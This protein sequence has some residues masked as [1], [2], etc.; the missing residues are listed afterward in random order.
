MRTPILLSPKHAGSV[1]YSTNAKEDGSRL[2][3]AVRELLAGLR[4]CGRLGR[5]AQRLNWRL[6]VA[7]RVGR[8][9]PAKMGETPTV[10]ARRDSHN[11][12][13]GVEQV[14]VCAAQPHLAQIRHWCRVE[15]TL[16]TLLQGTDTDLAASGDRRQ[17]EGQMGFR[18]DDVDCGAN[19]ARR[20]RNIASQE[21]VALRMFC[22]HKE[23]A[24][25]GVDE[26]HS[27]QWLMNQAARM[28]N[29][30]REPHQHI[31]PASGRWGVKWQERFKIGL[32]R[33]LA[34]QPIAE[35]VLNGV[36]FHLDQEYFGARAPM[37]RRNALG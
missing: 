9:E 12:R 13:V 28:E 27:D 19:R 16:E 7:G 26:R 37:Q 15:V 33:Q 18:F 25:Q 22:G 21:G 11:R 3:A 36:T 6:A 8:G 4:A 29:L 23:S 30:L 24:Y 2:L 34:A 10:C 35:G 14:L 31:D 5:P 20:R 32:R 17:R 1:D